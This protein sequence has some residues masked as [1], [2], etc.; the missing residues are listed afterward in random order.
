M[1]TSQIYF[2]AQSFE[3]GGSEEMNSLTNT[4]SLPGSNNLNTAQMLGG[5]SVICNSVLPK[6]FVKLGGSYPLTTA[7]D[8]LHVNYASLWLFSVYN[9]CALSKVIWPF[10]S[11]F[12]SPQK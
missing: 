4:E 10:F 5:H 11:S 12:L 2:T 8:H 1:N 7:F 3:T 9:R 6:H